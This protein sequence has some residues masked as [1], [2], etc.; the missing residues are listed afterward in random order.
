MPDSWSILLALSG[1][2]AWL[3]KEIISKLLNRRLA[4]TGRVGAIE[5]P[6]RILCDTETRNGGIVSVDY[7]PE[8]SKYPQYSDC[9]RFRA[10][11]ECQF[12]NDTD[13]QIVYTQAA[14]EYWGVEGLRLQHSNPSAFVLSSSSGTWQEAGTIAVSAHG[15][16]RAR[17]EVPIAF[18]FR[19]T[20]KAVRDIYG[21]SVVILRVQT[22][23]GKESSFRICTSSFAGANKVVWPANRKYPIFN[24]YSLNKRGRNAGRRP[25]ERDSG[26]NAK[27]NSD[28]EKAT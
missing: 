21:E 20:E 2:A 25:Q 4:R 9:R 3:S 18:D 5:G 12:F 14:L 26:K 1:W 27:S 15:V 28:G 17:F 22:I 13:T 8:M 16:T 7:F 24:V 11:F 23:S 6:A 10:E 19:A